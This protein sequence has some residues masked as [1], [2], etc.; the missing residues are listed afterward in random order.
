MVTTKHNVVAT[1]GGNHI[2]VSDVRINTEDLV[3]SSFGVE[4]GC[5]AVTQDNVTMCVAQFIAA[6]I[7]QV[8]CGTTDHNVFTI[9]GFDRIA[10]ADMSHI[11]GCLQDA[12]IFFEGY[13]AVVT[14][15]NVVVNNVSESGD[16]DVV[17]L[18]AEDNVITFVGCDCI[19]VTNL[20]CDGFNAAEDADMAGVTER[21]QITVELGDSAVTDDDVI[22]ALGGD[23]V[24]L[25]TTKHNVVA[26]T[27]GDVVSLAGGGL[28]N[29]II[30]RS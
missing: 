4:V 12:A 17:S 11:S 27:G 26:T 10:A 2:V 6:G 25:V 5:S 24:T 7:D 15:N 16:D 30:E 19:V 9:T 28:V 21:V 1:T 13:L 20:W 8:V 23:R 18:T 3:D 22:T 14:Q 29:G